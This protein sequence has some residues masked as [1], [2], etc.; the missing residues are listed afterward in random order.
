MKTLSSGE[1]T[2]S[3]V[4]NTFLVHVLWKI[5]NIR[6]NLF[7]G[8]L[9]LQNHHQQQQKIREWISPE[10]A[11]NSINEF[12]YDADDGDSFEP[13]SDSFNKYLLKTAWADPT[14]G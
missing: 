3:E 8:L 4:S 2:D 13:H 6:E 5:R 9:I 10:Y 11:S 12:K 1:I 7:V 14:K